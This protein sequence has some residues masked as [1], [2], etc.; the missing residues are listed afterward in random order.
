MRQKY[1]ISRRLPQVGSFGADT[2][3]RLGES[4]F[5]ASREAGLLT[6]RSYFGITLIVAVMF[7]CTRLSPAI[8]SSRNSVLL[9]GASWNGL[10]KPCRS[11]ARQ[12]GCLGLAAWPRH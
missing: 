4:R 5:D 12:N 7:G 2:S 6:A 8:Q 1:D 3:D 11:V 10:P 9:Y